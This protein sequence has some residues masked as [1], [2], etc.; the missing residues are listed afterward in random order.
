MLDELR[1]EGPVDDVR[2]VR[3]CGVDVTS[4]N[5]RRGE[6]IAVLGEAGGVRLEGGKRAR[7]G[8]QHLVLDLDELR[9]LAGG[10]AGL[11]GDAREHVADVRRRLADRDEL[12]PVLR[13]RSQAALAGNVACGQHG[14]HTRMRLRL[15]RVD[16]QDARTRMVGEAQSAVDHPR[17]AKIGD[18]RLVAQGELVGAVAQCALADPVAARLGQRLAPPG[19]GSKQHRVDHLH[20]ARATAEI[21]EQCVR[22]VVTAR[23]RGSLRGAPPTSSRSPASRS[24]TVRRLRL[25]SSRP[26]A[27]SSRRRGPPA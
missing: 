24:R 11:G 15:G 12:A 16:P 22:D 2:G 26:R 3:Q 14:D 21:A 10:M 19:A 20:V 25:R 9:R 27:S 8:L 23:R 1:A 5:E 4:P 7:D 6:H 17:L 13:Q 18:E